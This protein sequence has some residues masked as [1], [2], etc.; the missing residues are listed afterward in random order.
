LERTDVTDIVCPKT[1]ASADTSSSAGARGEGMRPEV[2]SKMQNPPNSWS[3][4]DNMSILRF[5]HSPK[6]SIRVSNC[7]FEVTVVKGNPKKSE[8]HL[9]FTNMAFN[10]G[11]HYWEI[12][13]PISCQDIYVGIYNPLTK[14]TLMETFKTTTPRSIFI[15]LDL[16]RNELKF[17]LN[18]H[19]VTKKIHKIDASGGIGQQWIPVI[20]IGRERNHAILNPFPYLPM[21]FTESASDRNFTMSKL[22]NPHLFN[23]ICVTGLPKM[24]TESSAA[25][26]ELK[27]FLHLSNNQLSKITLFK[28]QE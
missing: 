5:K 19:K 14:V 15:C 25:V 24:S 8:Y 1:G 27:N 7:G 4:E 22:L 10:I 2:E 16:N 13:C 6:T 21:D 3:F 18:E 26:D 11:V 17:W 20:M 23:T 28:T 12:I 9:V